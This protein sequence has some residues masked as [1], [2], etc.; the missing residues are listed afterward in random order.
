M[1][2]RAA[3][4][5][6]QPLTLM[7]SQDSKP[8][9]AS[10]TGLTISVQAAPFIDRAA[11][12]SQ[13]E[14]L[15]RVA[16]SHASGKEAYARSIAMELFEDFLRIEERFAANKNATEQEVIDAMRLVCVKSL[17]PHLL[18][19]CADTCLRPVVQ[20]PLGP[21]AVLPTCILLLCC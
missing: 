3:R 14:P 19:L 21:C 18:E 2:D 9:K 20:I 12:D 11:L 5:T 6:W 17:H 10:V 7:A 16:T 13:V 1:K 15:I 8:S 4:Q